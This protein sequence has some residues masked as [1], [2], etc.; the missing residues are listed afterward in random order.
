MTTE[1]RST[2]AE[3]ALRPISELAASLD[4]DPAE[5]E[6][7]GRDKAKIDLAV[8]ERLATRPMAS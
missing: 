5:V 4:L 7:F 2:A 8:L 1:A 3:S 6:L